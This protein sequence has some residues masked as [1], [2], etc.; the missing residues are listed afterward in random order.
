MTA[1]QYAFCL[2]YIETRNVSESAR[3]AGYSAT[4]SRARS[5][6]L[7]QHPEIKAELE[8]LEREYYQDH[9]KRLAIKS[10]KALEDVLE[11][12][13][14]ESARVSAAKEIFIRAGIGS[15]EPEAPLQITIVMP[16]GSYNE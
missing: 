11:N 9:F 3:I 2:N 5:H 7:L 8:K 16:K 13:E 1:K 14:N 10:I 15:I 12:G 6:E 4:Y